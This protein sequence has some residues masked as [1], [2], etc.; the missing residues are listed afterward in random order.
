MSSPA[1]QFQYD[2]KRCYELFQQLKIY[3]E[4]NDLGRPMKKQGYYYSTTNYYSYSHDYS[5]N[6]FSISIV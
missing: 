2:L 5:S 6:L 1:Q 3:L 4:R